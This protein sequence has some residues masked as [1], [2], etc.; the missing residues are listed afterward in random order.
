M[1]AMNL[2]HASILGLSLFFAGCQSIPA[3]I[4]VPE[5]NPA[6][7]DLIDYRNGLVL[8][9][10]GRPD[11]ALQLLQRARQAYPTNP[12]VANALGLTLLYRKDYKNALK[13]FND[14]LRLD[15][16]LVEAKT[17]RG[18]TYMETGLFDEAEADFNAILDGTETREKPNAHFNLGIL[19]GKRG[20]W[21]DAEREFSLVIA[22]DPLY[23]R[24]FKERGLARMRI[25]DF[26]G[27]LDDFLRYIKNDP[28]DAAGH[29]NAALCLLTTGRRD[30]AV[31]YMERTIAVAPD[32][33]E[34]R[35]AQRFLDSE[36]LASPQPSDRRGP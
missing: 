30:L 25:E 23:L 18:V 3:T 17:N 9:K 8:L 27:A 33:E 12:A 13:A 11:E 15:P 29:Y 19:M 7:T 4:K 26:R 21:A 24:A 10:E 34:A 14:A 6:L 1:K 35:K 22:D 5:E 31:R 20:R 2:K 36:A 16:N 32:S 28:K